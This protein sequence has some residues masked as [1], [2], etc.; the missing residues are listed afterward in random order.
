MPAYRFT[1][2]ARSTTGSSRG[3]APEKANAGVPNC[4]SSSMSSSRALRTGPMSGGI[5]E[6]KTAN[7]L[8]SPPPTARRKAT[9][10]FVCPVGGLAW[11]TLSIL[12]I[13]SG[14]SDLIGSP[15]NGDVRAVLVAVGDD[16][17]GV[18][19]ASPCSSRKPPIRIT[20]ATAEL[21]AAIRVRLLTCTCYPLRTG[22]YHHR[23]GGQAG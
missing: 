15:V 14:P 3:W 23:P 7:I 11:A 20:A 22:G 13:S 2:L 5:C 10:A 21:A 12:T 19:F 4:L 8:L 17:P 18:G 16:L 6:E 1:I 9:S